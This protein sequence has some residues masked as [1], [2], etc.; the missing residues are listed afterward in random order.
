MSFQDAA[1]KA[2]N[3]LFATFGQTAQLVFDDSTTLET[4]VVHRFPDKVVDFLDSKV[5]T[6][7]NLFEVRLSVLN[8]AKKIVQIIKNG[9]TYIVQGEPVKDQHGLVLSVDAY[10]S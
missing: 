8:P 1:L 3:V 10:A 9:K 4:V 5:Q 2:V 7:T 6:E